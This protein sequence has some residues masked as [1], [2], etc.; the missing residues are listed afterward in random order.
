MFL[1]Q[2][3]VFLARIL[4]LIALNIL[5]IFIFRISKISITNWT[6]W[7]DLVTRV[8]TEERTGDQ[9][10][11]QPLPWTSR[12][13]S[14]S[15][16][17][18]LA[19]PVLTRDKMGED[20]TIFKALQCDVLRKAILGTPPEDSVMVALTYMQHMKAGPRLE[21]GTGQGWVD[22]W[23]AAF[24]SFI[25]VAFFLLLLILESQHHS[26]NLFEVE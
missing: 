22:C 8:R 12:V 26:L 11:T 25:L 6:A 23:S 18:H 20:G 13:G 14:L 7:I 2:W 19:R 1:K 15:L 24:R 16:S 3:A 10:V 5:L 9:D 17:V 21:D 4:S